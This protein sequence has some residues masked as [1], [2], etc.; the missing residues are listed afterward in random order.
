PRSR[1]WSQ[2]VLH[3]AGLD[4]SVLPQ[5]GAGTQ[6]IGRVT[7]EFAAA[8]GL[9]P[10]TCVVLGC[11]DEMAATLGAGVFAAGAVC[12]V[13]G[14]AAPGCAAP[15]APRVDRTTL[16]DGHPHAAPDPS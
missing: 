13:V 14:T 6:A 1:E 11:G 8:T 4:A 2:P 16:D 9:A 10:D 12:D 5:L 7:K 15:P 3:A